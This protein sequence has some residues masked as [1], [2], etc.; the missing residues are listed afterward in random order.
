MQV[1]GRPPGIRNSLY[2]HKGSFKRNWKQEKWV[3][4]KHKS[5]KYFLYVAERLLCTFQ[6]LELY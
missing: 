5:R 6:L 2:V 1:D 3:A 4:L